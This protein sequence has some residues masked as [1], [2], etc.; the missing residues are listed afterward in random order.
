MRRLGWVLPAVLAAFLAGG[1]ARA[2]MSTV[3]L[4]AQYDE[5]NDSGQR[6]LNLVASST[7]NGSAWTN[8]YLKTVRK[9]EEIYCNDTGQGLTG[10]QVIAILREQNEQNEALSDLPFGLAMLLALKGHF[11]C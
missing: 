9:E 4:L 7:E 6:L 10:D 1:A 5:A 8:S 2:E 11:P 3:E